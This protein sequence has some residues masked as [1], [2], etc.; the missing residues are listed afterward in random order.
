MTPIDM[1]AP[2]PATSSRVNGGSDNRPEPKLDEG[3]RKLLTK[4]TDDRHVGKGAPGED[5]QDH[6]VGKRPGKTAQQTDKHAHSAGNAPRN[7]DRDVAGNDAPVEHVK[8]EATKAPVDNAD[9]PPSLPELLQALPQK[10]SA[11]TGVPDIV[12]PA[13]PGSHISGAQHRDAAPHE[14]TT[15]SGR[16][17]FAA[18]TSLLAKEDFGIESEPV[19]LADRKIEMPKITM[20]S[21]ETHFE[22]V[23]R[24][25]PAQQVATAIVGEL[26]TLPDDA[27]SRSAPADIDNLSLRTQS[28]GP[29]K[30]L[31]IKLE[32]DNLGE[33]S[34][35]MRLVGGTLELHLEASRTETLDMLTKD[36]D[37][38]NRLLR[39]SGYTPDVVTVQ[40]GADNSPSQSS[41]GQQNTGNSNHPSSAHNGAQPDSRR[42]GGEQAFTRNNIQSSEIPHDEAA[43]TSDRDLYL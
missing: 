15:E 20:V 31:H 21:R 32:P 7:A 8:D 28:N 22:P 4:L 16:D 6:P 27:A 5:D 17:P 24:I 42:G 13:R 26:T 9:V 10:A 14:S 12:S 19:S 43:L 41:T 18:L 35:K 34:V 37:V 33:V 1:A 29:L 38:L 30:I 36:K 23:I 2:A 25:A 39:A 40:A 3:F 11:K